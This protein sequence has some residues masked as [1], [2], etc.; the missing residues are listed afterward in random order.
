[1]QSKVNLTGKQLWTFITGFLSLSVA[2]IT[3]HAYLV[4]PK[5]IQEARGEWVKDIE[6]TTKQSKQERDVY[7]N[8]VDK[9]LDNL[10]HKFDK[11]FEEIMKIRK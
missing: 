7:M 2:L 1:M 11:L 10:D 9:R 4:V 5:I 8:S 6:S 3:L